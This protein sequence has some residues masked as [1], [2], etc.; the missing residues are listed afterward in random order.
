VPAGPEKS[1][2][3]KNGEGDEAKTAAEFHG[4]EAVALKGDS[5]AARKEPEIFREFSRRIGWERIAVSGV[6]SSIAGHERGQRFQDW[7]IG[8]ASG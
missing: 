2:D 3:Q 6:L 4:A 5:S 7:A 8:E 1:G